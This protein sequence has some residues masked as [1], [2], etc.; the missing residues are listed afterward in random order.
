MMK[1]IKALIEAYRLYKNGITLDEL[2]DLR[3]LEDV[4][5]EAIKVAISQQEHFNS[6]VKIGGIHLNWREA[7]YLIEG[8]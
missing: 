2:K 6:P 4:G 1:T 7:R 5:V 8:R 3:T